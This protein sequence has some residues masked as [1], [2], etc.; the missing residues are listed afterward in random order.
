MRG[1]K[2]RGIWKILSIIIGLCLIAIIFGFLLSPKD[3][4]QID[5]KVGEIV[6]QP[7]FTTEEVELFKQGLVQLVSRFFG[8]GDKKDEEVQEQVEEA[9]VVEEETIEQTEEPV[10]VSEPV[11]KEMVTINK[12]EFKEEVP[13][14]EIK[15]KLEILSDLVAR[16]Q[17]IIF[18]LEQN[19]RALQDEISA[20]KQEY[21]RLKSALNSL[22]DDIKIQKIEEEKPKK[23][24]TSVKTEG[25]QRAFRVG[26]I[27]RQ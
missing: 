17:E 7:E 22:R 19:N 1:M 21:A 23:K 4:K 16:K 24:S 3:N 10:I 25:D 9:I 11:I 6:E 18:L 5:E 26:R 27:P 15:L 13:L 8:V 2:M 20:L 12:T 14:Q